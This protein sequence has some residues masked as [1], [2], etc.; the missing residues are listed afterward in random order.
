MLWHGCVLAD[1]TSGWPLPAPDGLA[2]G[3]GT[4]AD[5]QGLLLI[6]VIERYA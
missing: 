3:P 2:G 5:A 4:N 1:V 6:L